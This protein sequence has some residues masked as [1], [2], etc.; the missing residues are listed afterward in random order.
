M[1]RLGGFHRA[2]IRLGV[3]AAIGSMLTGSG[4]A[5]IQ[6]SMFFVDPDG[7]RVAFDV[8]DVSRREV[9]HR[10]LSSKS[11]V[12][13]WVDQAFANERISGAFNGSIDAVLQ[14]LLAQTDF[15]A[16]YDRD[17][18]K[19]RIAR[20]IIVGKAASPSRSAALQGTIAPAP[21]PTLAPSPTIPAFA[22]APPPTA[23][24]APALQP[25]SG[26]IALAPPS[27]ADLAVPLITPAPAGMM[28]PAL[29]PPS[30]ADLARP[31]FVP[32]RAIVR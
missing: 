17:G 6:D 3:V 10:L 25:V 8:R 18:G 14:G 28:P 1:T 20:L 9:L 13:E 7:S 19:S 24:Q 15:V 4:S 32:P 2:W 11:V 31:I 12:L 27:P 5:G 16:V 22:P 23:A 21:S 29:V 26:S 30:A